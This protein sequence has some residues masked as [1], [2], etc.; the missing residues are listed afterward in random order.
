MK[1]VFYPLLAALIFLTSATML[2]EPTKYTVEDG[3]KVAFKSK[4]PSGV[5]KEMDGQINFDAKDLA[6]SKVDFTV[7]VSS[8]NTG[9][10]MQNKKAQISE[11]F[12]AAKYPD[13]TF[14]STKINE[15]KGTYYVYGNLTM[16]GT[17]KPYKVPMNVE[18]KD[19]GMKLTGS[20][21]VKRSDFKVG[22]PG[23]AVPDGM[24][25]IYSIPVSKN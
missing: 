19:N 8:I 11:W 20:F 24:K 13:I 1:N 4:D 15:Y 21:T 22:K 10:G 9:N 17:T 23:G 7:K 14:K 6:N 16:K 12:N 2:I 5:F 18:Y 3:F 25:I